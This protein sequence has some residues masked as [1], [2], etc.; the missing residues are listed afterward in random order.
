VYGL[1][2]EQN[3]FDRNGWDAAVPGAGAT[4]YSHNVYVKESVGNFVARGNLFANAASHGM[5][6]RAGGVVDQ[7]TFLDNPIHLS[8]GHVN[9]SP[10]KAGGVS[11]RV[12]ANLFQGGGSIGGSGR[13]WGIEAGNIRAGGGTTFGGNVFKGSPGGSGYAIYLTV[14]AGVTNPADA[15]GVNDLTIENNVVHDW[16]YGL[17]INNALVP[18]G[19]GGTALTNVTIRNNDFQRVQSRTVLYVGDDFTSTQIRLSGNRYNS[20]AGAVLVNTGGSAVAWTTWA[21]N[22][23]AGSAETLVTYADP[24]RTAGTYAGSLGLAATDG[25][26]VLAARRL[27]SGGWNGNLLGSAVASHVRNG[28]GV[29]GTTDPAPVSPPPVSPPPPPVSPPPVSPPPPPITSEP[30]P[31]GPVATDPVS[32]EPVRVKSVKKRR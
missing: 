2:L 10:V 23:D 6:A 18:G 12:T 29:L 8:F 15:V 16:S 24:S 3:V 13:G 20:A 4:I 31:T 21:P 27:S 28:F 7:N 14:G 11:G 5:Q 17:Y 1:V 22:R 25:G 32:T 30:V 26:Y 9:G 19:T